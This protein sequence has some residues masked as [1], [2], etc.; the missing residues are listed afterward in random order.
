VRQRPHQVELTTAVEQCNSTTNNN[1]RRKQMLPNET[2]DAVT[3]GREGFDYD[4]D[5]NFTGCAGE[6]AINLFKLHTLYS[7]LKLE[8]KTG[9]NWSSRF[10]T[11]AVANEMLGTDYKRKAKALEH[12]E[13][14]LVMAGEIQNPP[15]KTGE[16]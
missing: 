14:V 15:L 7:T 16:K 5:G 4:E 13:A 9:M 1:D 11:L 12:V 10:S 3:K 2:L 8:V 6:E